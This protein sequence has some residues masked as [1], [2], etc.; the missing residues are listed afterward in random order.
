MR[1]LHKFLALP[2][3][4]RLA[5]LEATFC[6]ALARLCLVLLP[7]SSISKFL[8][9]YM[10]ETLHTKLELSQHATVLRISWGIQSAAR[11]LPGHTACLPK[12]IAARMMLNRRGIPCT[13][14]LGVRRNVPRA[15]VDA[16]AWVRAG[17]VEVT[18][19]QIQ[20]DFATI[21]VFG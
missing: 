14:Y 12:S 15:T 7:F 10:F 18:P 4:K 2:H 21:A 8:G 20:C 11:F 1:A 9:T 19:R 13:L 17:V 16:H 3:C 6:V 5:L